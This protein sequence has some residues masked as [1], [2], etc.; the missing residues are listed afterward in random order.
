MNLY[1]RNPINISNLR[2]LMFFVYITIVED[3]LSFIKS[4]GV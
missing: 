2:K 4:K 3:V 1:T